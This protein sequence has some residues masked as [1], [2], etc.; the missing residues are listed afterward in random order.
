MANTFWGFR[1][2]EKPDKYITF[3]LQFTN[4][5]GS[6]SG[7]IYYAISDTQ[8]W[9]TD[10]LI[11]TELG[12]VT[13]FR[14][15][16]HYYNFV[17]SAGELFWKEVINKYIYVK[18]QGNIDG[19]DY[20]Q[21]SSLAMGNAFDIS[22]SISK[23][24]NYAF[25]DASLRDVN[26]NILSLSFIQR[27]EFRVKYYE[28]LTE[29][30]EI[31]IINANNEDYRK[32][33]IG[34]DNISIKSFDSVLIDDAGE[35]TKLSYTVNLT[36]M[37]SPATTV[38]FDSVKQIDAA[39]IQG[40]II[41]NGYLYGSAKGLDT[42]THNFVRISLSD[43]DDI[44][45]LDIPDTHGNRLS[46]FSRIIAVQGCLYAICSGYMVQILPDTLEWVRYTI[47]QAGITGSDIPVVGDQDHVFILSDRLCIKIAAADL[48][49]ITRNDVNVIPLAKAA[50]TISDYVDLKGA[51]M[52]SAVCDD[53]YLYAAYTNGNA[54][55]YFLLK[56]NKEK[57]TV[58]A[59]DKI[60][61]TT[62]TMT[63]NQDYLFLGQKADSSSLGY[64]FGS[65]AFRKTDLK[66]FPLSALANEDIESIYS[67]KVF[68]SNTSL[69]FGDY[70]FDFKTNGYFY[71]LDTLITGRWTTDIPG[72]A[73]RRV[74]RYD[75][76]SIGG[77]INKVVFDFDTQ[78]F[79]AFVWIGSGWSRSGYVT[80]SI[81]GIEISTTPVIEIGNYNA[82]D[83][84]YELTAIIHSSGGTS[85]TEA[86]FELSDDKGRM[87]TSSLSDLTSGIKKKIISTETSLK[88]R[89]VAKNAKGISYSGY[90]DLTVIV[91]DPVFVI[92][93]NVYYGNTPVPG[94][95]VSL[96]DLDG[97][98]IITAVQTDAGGRYSFKDLQEN[99]KYLIFG[100]QGDKRIIPKIKIPFKGS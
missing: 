5:V 71:L 64:D 59:W 51:L 62:G 58:E 55:D 83:G 32:F 33:L 16:A 65:V 60:P 30:N 34:E 39:G 45:Y 77:E 63:R 4:A 25:L 74:F 47:S 2:T 84:K 26:K 80:F 10:A 3:E 61:E 67:G 19:D 8:V 36:Y 70:L 11:Y 69:L 41:Y 14:N 90:K 13:G 17:Y 44:R 56:I 91:P 28:G 20:L 68:A 7:K 46:G 95:S 94:V 29:K 43:P 35:E 97:G 31:R 76:Y 6:A 48:Q 81:P 24:G 21:T 50:V 49:A 73:T 89:F 23:S 42:G 57:M 15:E 96:M 18:F 100:F 82:Q 78:K 52:R 88:Y 22:K 93:G 87:E 27:M 86:Y 9:N 12:A 72:M 79:H 98:S 99:K 1:I 38:V 53:A 75:P 37:K 92:E 54:P 85:V 40:A 66:M